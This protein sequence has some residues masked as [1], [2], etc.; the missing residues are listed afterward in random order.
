MSAIG[1]VKINFGTLP[2]NESKIEIKSPGQF[3]MSGEWKENHVSNNKIM[4]QTSESSRNSNDDD[5]DDDDDN[6][7]GV[8]FV[9]CGY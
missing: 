5:D 7:S 1:S 4:F 3:M 2:N 8:L 9:D 6:S